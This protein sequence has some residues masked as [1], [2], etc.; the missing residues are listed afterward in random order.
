MQLIARDVG[1]LIERYSTKDVI[2]VQLF[3]MY[4]FLLD[5]EVIESM[6]L[7]FRGKPVI[8]LGEEDV[9]V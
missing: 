3:C 9:H 7:A 4:S 2:A 5:L 1:I 8:G 6:T